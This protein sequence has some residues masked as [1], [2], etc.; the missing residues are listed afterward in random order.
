MA[1]TK[2]ALPKIFLPIFKIL[3]EVYNEDV[4]DRTTMVSPLQLCNQLIDWT[5]P[6]KAV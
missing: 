1:L 5:D 6:R 4:E 2:R 3:S